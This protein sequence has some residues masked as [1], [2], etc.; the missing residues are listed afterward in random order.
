MPKPLTSIAPGMSVFPGDQREDGS[1]GIIVIV[2]IL[3]AL[4]LRRL[5]R[6]TCKDLVEIEYILANPRRGRL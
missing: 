6:P 4:V 5:G 2:L 1:I 3:I